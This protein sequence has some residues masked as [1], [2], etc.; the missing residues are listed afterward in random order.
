M[1]PQIV[2]I[3]NHF[4]PSAYLD[5][6]T[7]LTAS[8]PLSL[9]ITWSRR[10]E[11]TPQQLKTRGSGMALADVSESGSVGIDTAPTVWIVALL[12]SVV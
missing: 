11:G 8:L 10:K 3:I 12:E 1:R 2:P 7:H 4:R 5:V 6:D 9:T